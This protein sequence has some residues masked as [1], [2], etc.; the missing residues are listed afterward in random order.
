MRKLLIGLTA[1]LF[2]GILLTATLMWASVPDLMLNVRPSQLAFDQTIS[3]IKR[4]AEAEGWKVPKV[5]DIQKSLI[6]AGYPDAPRLKV[7]SICQPGH[8]Y[9]V[10]KAVMDRRVT[11][12][13]PCRISV[14]E[15]DDGTVYVA[16]LNVALMGRLFGGT[17]GDV[18]RTVAQDQRTILRP[19]LAH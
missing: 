7:L 5:Y 9:R 4:T 12:M 13:M 6:K 2:G 16:D 10:T 17:V 3:T 15:G 14:F 1:G 19:V 18:M 11:A 8:A